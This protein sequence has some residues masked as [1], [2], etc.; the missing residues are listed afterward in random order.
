MTQI[1]HY[2]ISNE[3]NKAK[4]AEQG[5]KNMTCFITMH[6]MNLFELN[7]W[8]HPSAFQFPRIPPGLS[9]PLQNINKNLKQEIFSKNNESINIKLENFQQMY[10]KYASGLLDTVFPGIVPPGHPLYSRE[11]SVET[12]RLERDK[13]LQ[14]NLELK[15]Q[16][17]NLSKKRSEIFRF[18]NLNIKNP[19]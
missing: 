8:V 1:S 15:K 14:E 6:M 13:L 19:Y 3:N 16:L 12:L 9:Y 2:G 4:I 11:F 7:P 5:E 17:N 10:R 18:D